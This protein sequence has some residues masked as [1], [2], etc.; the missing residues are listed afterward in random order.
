MYRR[1]LA[2]FA[3]LC[4]TLS[5]F[6]QSKNAN[7][8]LWRISGNGLKQPSYLFGTMHLTDKRLFNF[9]DS[10]YHALEVTD[11]TAIEVNPDEMMAYTF[12]KEIEN[13]QKGKLLKEM[14]NDKDYKK[15]SAALSK[16]LNKPA[17]E[18]TE[19]D[20]LLEKNSWTSDY[21][22]KG[23]MPTFVDAYLFYTAKKQAKWVGGIE[24]ITDQA[25]L[26]E[27]IDKTDI[28]FMLNKNAKDVTNNMM[29]HMIGLYTSQNVD[30]LY[31]F[32]SGED[33]VKHDAVI[34][35][36]NV[37][38]AFRIDSI[39]R[40]RSMLFAIGA[41]HLASDEGVINLLR[42]RGFTVTPVMGSKKISSKDYKYVEKPIPWNIVDD[43]QGLYTAMMPGS[44]FATKIMGV[45]DAEFYFDLSSFTGYCT[46][47]TLSSANVQSKDSLYK[48]FATAVFKDGQKIKGTPVNRNGVDGIE[49]ISQIDN[50]NARVQLFMKDNVVYIPMFYAL[51]KDSLL[52]LNAK[53]FFDS[54]VI[55]EIPKSEHKLYYDTVAGMVITFPVPLEYNKQMSSANT[56]GWN[57][58]SYVGTDLNSGVF[59][60][61]FEKSPIRGNYITSDST[62]FAETRKG[63]QT[64]MNETKY[65]ELQ[66]AGCNASYFE[67]EA[68]GYQGRFLNII[69]GNHNIGLM[70]VGDSIVAH[71]AIYDNVFKNI[72]LVPYKPIP[73]KTT[74]VA[75]KSLTVWAPADFTD[76]STDSSLA[77]DHFLSYDSSSLAT[78]L[79]SVDTLSNYRWYDSDSAF[80][81]GSS[82]HFFARGDSLVSSIRSKKGS[83][84]TNEML[85]GMKRTKS[86]SRVKQYLY[87]NLAYQILI[88]GELDVVNSSDADRLLNDVQFNSPLKQF[89]I[90]ESKAGLLLNDLSSK[91]SAAATQAYTE[92]SVAKF[93]TTN[94]TL[95]HEC[96][97]KK[98]PK[99]YK[100]GD[101][102]DVNNRIVSK[103]SE[104]ASPS[105]V[106]FVCA[107]YNSL[108]GD[109]KYLRQGLIRL[110]SS[111]NTK[112]SYD[113][114]FSL[115]KAHPADELPFSFSSNVADSLKL[116]A[117]YSDDI[118]SFVKDTARGMQMT[119]LINRLADSNLISLDKIKK[120]END[121]IA[122]SKYDLSKD[123]QS[124]RSSELV[125]VLGKI[126]TQKSFAAVRGYL[127]VKDAKY[128]KQKAV[129]TLI[130]N[131][132]PVSDAV[133][134]SMAADREMRWPLFKDLKE[135]KKQALFPKLYLSQKSLGESL[136]HEAASDDYSVKTIKF[137]AEKTATLHNKKY[138]FYLFKVTLDEDTDSY[139]G[140]AG[141]Y[142]IAGKSLEPKDDITSMYFEEG[143]DQAKI[144]E[145]FNAWLSEFETE[146]D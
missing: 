84:S 83:I 146:R 139:L 131:N 97:L 112:Q 56:N 124:W 10:L 45:I 14:L 106:T 59:I 143:F 53:K 74:S 126:K 111:I 55:K 77:E 1:L 98:Y 72:K 3:F 16:K 49:Y 7:T 51:R 119:G 20:L 73:W 99:P 23:E 15:Y 104:L 9:D 65:E 113:S 144:D 33:S 120:Y 46:V 2:C 8:L 66:V 50:M 38:M 89:S 25:G 87:G 58:K 60:A 118:L 121:F 39:A 80:W 115:L 24:D 114:L 88:K 105:T 61:K 5:S 82:K 35:R 12:N 107:N 134:N 92:M 22:A 69:R 135:I 30:E 40:T 122:L 102:S 95:L 37:K 6:S 129:V 4:V 34:T 110:L 125:E 44:P 117:N 109:R 142:D 93:D 138:K 96:L 132:Q 70:V 130:K 75:K 11:G 100:Y 63:M 76:N 47:A 145:Q 54:F 85:V 57:I 128:V 94:L 127:N 27:N 86:Y 123:E 62:I 141:A 71:K 64:K 41:A 28:E 43:K 19:K 48:R 67:G 68:N 78:I 136:L 13:I 140:V 18:I 79:V 17:S 101:T 21:L 91:D 52:G 116:A 137:I 42:K 81:E 26:L 29:E 31:R 108:T 103:L 32:T 133:I 90:T 36:R